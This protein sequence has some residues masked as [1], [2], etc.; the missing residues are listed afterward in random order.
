MAVDSGEASAMRHKASPILVPDGALDVE[1]V[2]RVFEEQAEQLPGDI[3]RFV[4]AA[5]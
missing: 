3:S 2:A 1:T 5:L 4:L